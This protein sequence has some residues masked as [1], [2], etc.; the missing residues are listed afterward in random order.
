MTITIPELFLQSLYLLLATGFAVGGIALLIAVYRRP[1]IAISKWA[2]SHQ[3]TLVRYQYRTLRRGPFFRFGRWNN[4]A[5]VFSIVVRDQQGNIRAGWAKCDAL[6]S[7]RDEMIV[8]VRWDALET[9]KAAQ[10]MKH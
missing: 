9:N 1:R 3:Y 6:K 8:E 2:A 5:P 7:D 10:S 4:L